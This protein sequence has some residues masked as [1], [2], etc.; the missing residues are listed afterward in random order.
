MALKLY[1][2]LTREKELFVPHEKNLVRMYNCGPTVYWR[3]QLGNIRAYANWDILHRTLLYLG[4]DVDRVVNF[5]DVGHMTE[6]EDF[7]MIRSRILQDQKEK[8]HKRSRIIS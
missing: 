6:D 7:E 2:T 5:T 3:M 1:N 4:Y 8:H